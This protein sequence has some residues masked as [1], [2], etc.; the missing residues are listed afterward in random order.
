MAPPTP[1]GRL[2]LPPSWGRRIWG[3]CL[4]GFLSLTVLVLVDDGA[5]LA[6][7][8]AVADRTATVRN[9]AATHLAV[10]L[11]WLGLVPAVAVWA[12][13]AAVLVDRRCRTPWRCV[14]RVVAVLCLDVVLVAAVKRLVDRPR[15]P[16]DGWLVTVSTSS[17]PS[18]HA[19]ATAA[20]V[21]VLVLS[22]VAARLSRRTR[23]GTLIA[24]TLIVVAMDWSRVYLG[25]HYLTDV[26]AGTLLGVWLAVSAAWVHDAIATRRRHRGV[27]AARDAGGGRS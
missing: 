16:S 22:V 14:L 17:F 11:G 1:S 15:P 6:W 2:W 26:V 13:T 20:A 23:V 27:V 25:V 4:A 3:L 21:A 9:D 5:A 7:D 18:G 12:G 10:A 8:V 24:A 19:T